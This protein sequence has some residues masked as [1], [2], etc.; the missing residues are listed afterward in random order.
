MSILANR[1][2]QSKAK[3]ATGSC[4]WV[5]PLGETGAGVLEIRRG[6]QAALYEVVAFHEEGALVGYR[7]Q[8]VTGGREA[9]YDIDV[10]TDPWTCDC[11]DAVYRGAER[12]GGCKHV[13]ALRA[14]LA[15]AAKQ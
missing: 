13:L 1:Q 14:A 2:P 10:R 6:R 5:V 3:P 4:R 12:P 8:K 7:L 15:A 9:M 11:P